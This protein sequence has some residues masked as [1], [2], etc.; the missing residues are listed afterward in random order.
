VTAERPKRILS[1]LAAMQL[2]QTNRTLD[3]FGPPGGSRA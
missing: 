3:T 2:P 1:A